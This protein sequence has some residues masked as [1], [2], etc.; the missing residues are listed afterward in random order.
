M[1]APDA[2]FVSSILVSGSCFP[3]FLWGIWD[4]SVTDFLGD[5]LG[6]ISIFVLKWWCTSRK[7]DRFV[8]SEIEILRFYC[9][10]FWS[11]PKNWIW[12]RRL[13]V[14]LS[15]GNNRVSVGVFQRRRCAAEDPR[16]R[17]FAVVRRRVAPPYGVAVLVASWISSSSPSTNFLADSAAARS[18]VC[19]GDN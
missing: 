12:M 17:S 6:K 8:W 4:S 15:V 2:C 9:F 11:K 1:C 19:D 18:V 5:F 7:V 13:L 3:D 10:F 16:R 14:R